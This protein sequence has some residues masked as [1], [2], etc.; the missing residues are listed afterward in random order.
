MRNTLDRIND[1]LNIIEGNTVNLNIIETIQNE[2]EKNII[3]NE[4]SI[5]ESWDKYG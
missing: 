5:T 3:L 2:M 4:K 1:K